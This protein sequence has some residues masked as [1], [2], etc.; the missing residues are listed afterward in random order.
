MLGT[1]QISLGLLQGRERLDVAMESWRQD[2]EDVNKRQGWDNT[3]CD[4]HVRVPDESEQVSM[5]SE[6]KAYKPD[7]SMQ[8]TD[9]MYIGAHSGA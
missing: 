4:I 6:R 2:V 8:E 9:H 1:M 3:H 5:K 7:A